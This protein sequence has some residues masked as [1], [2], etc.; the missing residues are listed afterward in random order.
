MRSR[1]IG[2]S[3]Q[4]TKGTLTGE[5]AFQLFFYFLCAALF[6]WVRA[7]APQETREREGDCEG[8]HPHI[9]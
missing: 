7:P 2:G 6:V 9:L 5:A 1:I 4:R 3:F 8:L